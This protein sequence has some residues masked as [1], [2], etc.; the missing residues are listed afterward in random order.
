MQLQASMGVLL[1]LSWT[2]ALLVPFLW[3]ASIPAADLS[4]WLVVSAPF[5]YFIWTGFRAWRLGWRSRFILR[6]VIP[7]ALLIASVVVRL[8]FRE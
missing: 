8:T 7:L 3:D 5:V 4:V 6:L 2:F 1:V